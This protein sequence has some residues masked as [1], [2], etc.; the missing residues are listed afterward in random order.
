MAGLGR[1]LYR[2]LMRW[3]SKRTRE[4]FGAEMLAVFDDAAADAR[5]RGIWSYVRFVTRELAGLLPGASGALTMTGWQ[6]RW[7]L[8]GAAAGLAVGLALAWAFPETYRSTTVVRVTPSAIPERFV[9]AMPMLDR[10]TLLAQSGELIQSRQTLLHIIQTF[11]LYKSERLLMPIEDVTDLMRQRIELTSV[12]SSTIRIAFTY[13][14]RH[15]AQKVARHLLT[16]LIDDVL[17][18]R[19]ATSQMTV[20]FLRSQAERAAQAWQT[21]SA[22]VRVARQ[23]DPNLERLHLDRDLARR[24]YE[25]LRTLLAEAQTLDDLEQRR[26]GPTMEVLDLPSLP[27]RAEWPHRMLLAASTLSGLVLGLLAEWVRR[28]AATRVALARAV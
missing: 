13:Y 18:E 19:G 10:D 6:W 15:Q 12:K 21:Q 4:E 16:R 11:D 7:P 25:S 17:R 27:E 1:L 22:A 14:D 28:T 26:Q 24:R 20:E 8:S 3:Q 9:P 23:D 2:G 5:A